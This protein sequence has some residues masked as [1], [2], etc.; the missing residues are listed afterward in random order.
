[1]TRYLERD[2]LRTLLASSAEPTAHELAGTLVG[3]SSE[4]VAV[5]PVEAATLLPTFQ[6]RLEAAAAETGP[7]TR[8]LARFVD[9]LGDDDITEMFAVT[10]GDVTGIGLIAASGQVVAVTLVITGVA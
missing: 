3:E 7:E 4:L 6:T 9:V 8:G 2:A 5:T 1:M 10:E